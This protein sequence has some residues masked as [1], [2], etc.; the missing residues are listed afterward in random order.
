[1]IPSTSQLVLKVLGTGLLSPTFFVHIKSRM[2]R[3]KLSEKLQFDQVLVGQIGVPSYV[4]LTTFCL[5]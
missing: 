1:M 3:F 4:S 5:P 2:C